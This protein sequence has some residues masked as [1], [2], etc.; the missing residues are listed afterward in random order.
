MNKIAKKRV[1]LVLPVALVMAVS[2]W[3]V[4]PKYIDENG[5]EQS[6]P[7]GYTVL[8]SS[9]CK[10][11]HS[12]GWYVVESSFTCPGQIKFNGSLGTGNARLVIADGQKLSVSINGD[13]AIVGDNLY[14]Y[15]QANRSGMI[16]LSA[17]GGGFWVQ[18]GRSLYVTNLYVYGVSISVESQKRD[19]LCATSNISIKGGNIIAIA[20]DD[21]YDGIKAG[22]TMTNSG[23]VTLDWTNLTD[24]V[25][26]S[27]YSGTVKIASGKAFKDESGNV[28]EAGT[29]LSSDQKTALK[30][31]YLRPYA[32]VVFDGDKAIVDGD[33]TGSVAV[34]FPEGKTVDVSS[35]DY[36][37][38]FTD[39][40]AAT[41][42]L[43]FSLPEGAS[44]N[45]KFYGLRTI[46]QE[47]CQWKA[48]MKNIGT[49]NLPAANTPYIVK[50]QGTT[51][52]FD[53]NG[54]KAHLQ[55]QATE[56]HEV[57]ITGT[58]TDN[59]LFMGNYSY[60]TWADDGN[61]GLYYALFGEGDLKG[62]FGKVS[63][64]ST[65][66]AMRSYFR[67]K[68]ENVKIVCSTPSGRPAALG[69]SAIVSEIPEVIEVELI[70]EDDEGEHTTFV[71]RMNTR[72]GEIQMKRDYDLKGRKL[73]G[74]PT[75]RGA[76]YGKKV[77][78]K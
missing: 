72:T 74:A 22:C 55:T 57:T 24:Y 26:A 40:V 62:W 20:D 56:N 47:G 78:K 63:T 34:D 29:T 65:A 33:Y 64:T 67:K 12:S 30:N 18:D 19:G 42:V 43:P 68:D 17:T 21:G 59:W 41:V 31:K 14:I 51:L 4:N 27:S 46:V 75:A 70:D 69:E 23:T 77:I 66:P 16:D 11:S 15:G 58:E 13:D 8:N 3:A 50:V 49:G 9:N 7:D 28:Y 6:V 54:G 76:Y 53:L 60:R 1:G 71:G 38:E 48:K 61:V 5:V 32:P 45:A 35:I 10:G 44:V 37:R 25:K 36:Q 73:N 39:D 2:S 52:T